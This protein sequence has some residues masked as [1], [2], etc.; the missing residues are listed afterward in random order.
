MKLMF[1][2]A[3]GA[4]K[5]TQAEKISEKYG[6]PSISTGAILREAMANGSELGMKAKSFV[7]A[8]ALVP[9]EVVIGIIKERLGKD[10]CKRGFILDGFPRTVPQAKAL[11]EMGITMDAVISIEVDDDDIVE[12][13]GGRRLCK[14]C[15]TAYHIKHIPTKVEGVCDKCGG[16]LY[17]RADDKPEVVKDRL[18]TYHDQ[19][20][21]LK[22]FYAEKGKLTLIPGNAPIDSIT[23][24]ICKVLDSIRG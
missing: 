18:K 11:D 22:D 2:G 15:G 13:M 1:L 14:G 9:D 8:G 12:R 4:G 19:T 6:I 21:P 20:E 10:D 16:E 23:A 3:P 7:S 5:G 24:E 17:V